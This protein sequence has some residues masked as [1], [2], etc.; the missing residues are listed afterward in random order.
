[1]KKTTLLLFLIAGCVSIQAANIFVKAGATGAANG[2]SW[3]D[4]YT[5]IAAAN[6]AA[7]NGDVVYVAA[8]TYTEAS[9][10]I[11]ISKVYTIKG[12]YT[13]TETEATIESATADPITNQ[14]K[15]RC[16]ASGAHGLSLSATTASISGKHVF[17]GL[18]FYNT[19]AGATAF[20]GGLYA[21]NFL[22]DIDIKNCI[23]DSN[24]AGKGGAIYIQQ[25]QTAAGTNT[26]T[27]DNCRFINNGNATSNGTGYGGGAIWAGGNTTGPRTVALSVSNTQFIGNYTY[28]EGGAIYLNSAANLTTTSNVLFRGNVARN[29]T[30]STNGLGGAIYCK[31]KNT[32]S[33][34]GT[35][36][37]SNYSANKGNLFF[38]V[39]AAGNNISASMTNVV[40]VGNHANNSGQASGIYVNNYEYTTITFS[41]S[42]FANNTQ[43]TGSTPSNKDFN[44]GTATANLN[45][46]YTLSNTILGGLKTASSTVGNIMSSFTNTD[47]FT[48]GKVK[49]LNGSTALDSVM[50]FV[51]TSETVTAPF[52]DYMNSAVTV[53]LKNGSNNYTLASTSGY[54]YDIEF[55]VRTA[56]T[57]TISPSSGFVVT[58]GSGNAVTSLT[59]AGTYSYTLRRT[60]TLTGTATAASAYTTTYGTPSAAQ[61]FAV[62]GQYL[63]NDMTA[64]A[65]TGFE[66]SKDGSTYSS[67]V[68][69]PQIGG[70]ASGTLYVRL[71]ANAAV[72]GAYNSKN[73]QLVSSSAST[74]YIGSTASGNTVSKAALTITAANQTV[75]YGT[76]A[77][78]VTGAGTYTPTGF[79]NSET[80]SVISGTAT[81][82]TNFTNTTAAGA[83]GITITP[84][85]SG[86]SATNYDF[87]PAN[88]TITV[89]AADVTVSA[90]NT[91]VSSLI[92]SPVSNITVEGTGSLTINQNTEV[93]SIAVAAG[94]KLTIDNGRTLSGTVTLESSD[95]KTATLVDDYASPTV[96]ATV[97]QHVEEGRNWY[98]SAPVTAAP[99]TWL[100]R[101]T[102]VQTWNELTKA[103]VP[104]TSD[105]VP[106]KGYVQVATS[107][108]TV[109]G[110]TGTVNVTGT[111][112]SGDITV[113][114]TRTESGSSRG[115]N[116][117]GNP[118]P[119]YLKWKGTDSFLADLTND[120]ISTSFWYRT[121]NTGGAY[122]FTT[123]NG[124]SNEVVGGTTATTLLNE[125]IP[126]MQAFWIRVNQNTDISSHHV[127]LTF[128]N[129]M[130]VHGTG[131]NNKFKSPRNEQRKRLR[132]QL[133]NGMN[134]DE[135]LIYFDAEAQNGFDTYDSP[136][137]MNNS[138][139]IP[140][141]YSKAST[142]KL[143]INGLTEL[144]NNLELPLG[145]NIGAAA[146]LTLKVNEMTNFDSNTRIYLRD[147]ITET[148][149]LPA[150]EYTFSTNAATVNE[151]RFSLIFRS[152]GVA[153]DVANPTNERISVVVN[154]QNNIVINANA[155]SSY[156]IYN[157][158]GQRIAAGKT[159]M[160]RETQNTKLETG[161]YIVKVNNVSKRIIVK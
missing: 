157:S 122:I 85:V 119:S 83:S 44:N 108:P 130:R 133:A 111:T 24:T 33:L 80:A 19:A 79:V 135:T 110:T 93:A 9:A 74:Q 12:G 142:E 5:T 48:Q 127:K 22:N 97:Q 54:S 57:Y 134:T 3:A 78:T 123:Y 77:E 56:G 72:T 58:D 39:A 86:L 36:F 100:N 101:G 160:K 45:N 114:V 161:V 59:S 73:V 65:P 61:T 35:Q 158:L 145:Y 125:Y 41:N 84:D 99:Y 136:K 68:S 53:K 52:Y 117:V 42:T 66:V 91:S 95:T 113:T 155:G 98:I 64:N 90:S 151:S 149:L 76:L 18:Y 131:D 156:A 32:L 16:T 17:D 13:G 1:M 10:V 26:V 21:I 67:S 126:P 4:A 34:T 107:T 28:P 88:G 112:N 144:T 46:N 23:F 147:G 129:N 70:N 146:S 148:E 55:Y 102:S 137:M 14:V 124:S 94:G 20:G 103:W 132:L 138:I 38:N 121:K 104:V 153:T 69:F 2:T 140:D 15:I 96:S 29:T 115:F 37:I 62:T 141:L 43:A 106:G 30:G 120:S 27:I 25:A 143:A 6:T 105:L 139:S 118:Y 63:I 50:L 150:T 154:A 51:G 47:Y 40:S 81:Y 159:N 11:S 71:K 7:A 87:T 31:N 82:T 152:P 8:G 128:K 75:A 109:T 92:I 116:L 60:P 49:V 89:A